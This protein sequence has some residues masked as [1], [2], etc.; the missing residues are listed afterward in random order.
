MV[1]AAVTGTTG[2]GWERITRDQQ[3]H[4]AR[5]TYWPETFHIKKSTFN[6]ALS[7]PAG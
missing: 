5:K 4:Q 2:C 7:G 1:Y 3:T 6:N